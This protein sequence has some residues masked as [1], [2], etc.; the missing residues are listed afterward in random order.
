VYSLGIGIVVTGVGD[1]RKKVFE[2]TAVAE[3]QAGRVSSSCAPRVENRYSVP[4][5][6]SVAEL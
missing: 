4:Q 3:K 6:G 5:T 1:T 2:S